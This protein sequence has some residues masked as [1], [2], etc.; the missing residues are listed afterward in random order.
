MVAEMSGFELGE[1]GQQLGKTANSPISRG[2]QAL[3]PVRLH[4]WNRALD[5]QR[6]QGP[7]AQNGGAK[8]RIPLG[9]DRRLA[10]SISFQSRPNSPPHL[11]Q[12]S[13]RKTLRPRDRCAVEAWDDSLDGFRVRLSIPRSPEIRTDPGL[14]HVT[15]PCFPAPIGT[16]RIVSNGLESRFRPRSHFRRR[17]P[18]G[19]ILNRFASRG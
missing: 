9:Q 10:S 5:A 2:N 13:P 14:W 6:F 18:D 12:I 7:A 16:V 19:T 4:F 1:T 8:G 15:P 3:K 11:R 17:E